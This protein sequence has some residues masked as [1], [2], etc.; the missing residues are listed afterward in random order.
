MYFG[1]F[2]ALHIVS[3]VSWFAGLL[4]VVR[5][6]VYITEAHDRTHAESAI[7]LPQLKLMARRLWFGITWP[8]GIATIVFGTGMIHFFWPMPPWLL[9]KVGLV[10]LLCG[11]HLCC[12]WIHRRLQADEAPLSSRALRIW[13]EVA[14]LLLVCIVFVVVLKDPRA[15]VWA[16][17]GFA[18]FIGAL[19]AGITAYRRLRA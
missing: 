19:M 12:H 3:V 2:K 6:F 10:T 5:L 18:V 7:L 9:V 16:M 15:M 14:T 13:N 1:V 17:G 4:Y 11:Y 8:A